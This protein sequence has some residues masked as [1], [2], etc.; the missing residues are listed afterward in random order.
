M[1]EAVT[2][3]HNPSACPADHFAALTAVH[4]AD[5]LVRASSGET[6]APEAVLDMDYLTRIG[7]IH[8]LPDWEAL[9]GE[10]MSRQSVL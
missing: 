6:S 3:H 7:V 4:V 8:E 9:A 1:A 2:F 10:V 5:A